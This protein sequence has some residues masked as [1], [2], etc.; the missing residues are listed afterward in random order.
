M[1]ISEKALL[2]TAALRFNEELTLVAKG[3]LAESEFRRIF[4]EKDPFV[5]RYV[6]YLTDSLYGQQVKE[7]VL[8]HHEIPATWW[9]SFKRRWFSAWLLQKYPAKVIKIPVVVRHVHVCPHV[10]V[11]KE[12]VHFDFVRD[13]TDS[14]FP[15]LQDYM[16]R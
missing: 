13:E 15:T 10:N 12:S 5:H 6:V 3:Y 16:A 4:I 9:D 11:K 8:E 1:A 14:I 7:E 2:K